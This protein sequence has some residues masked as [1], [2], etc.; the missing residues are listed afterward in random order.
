[1]LLLVYLW[2]DF[3][4]LRGVYLLKIGFVGAGK[5]G[6]VFGWYLKS[7]GFDV[8]GY[9][10]RTQESAEKAALVTGTRIYRLYDIVKQSDILFITTPDAAID[11]VDELIGKETGFKEGQTVVHM[12]G[13]LKSSIMTKAKGQGANIFSLHPMQ[14]FAD[15]EKSKDEIK[16]T[17]FTYEGEGE[18][19]DLLTLLK[20]MENPFTKI[21]PEHKYL[22]HAAAC[23]SSNYLVTLVSMAFEVFNSIG[24]DERESIKVLLPLM[25]GTLK[26][27]ENLG[28]EKALTGPLVRGDSKTIETHLGK[29]KEYEHLHK[30]YCNLGIETLKIAQKRGLTEEKLDKISKILRECVNNG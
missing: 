1:M 5:V 17:F 2:V 26:N 30:N 14:S 18:D 12:S 9:S 20:S 24:F 19:R 4:I 29:L 6:T 25:K 8:I 16:N 13:A 27:I 22:Y 11:E 3:F 28:V 23:I 7:K 10:S 15:F 21:E